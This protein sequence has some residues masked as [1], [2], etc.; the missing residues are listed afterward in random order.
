MG[1]ASAD[2][3]PVYLVGAQ[4]L[5]LGWA[6]RRRSITEVVD[7]GDKHGVAIDAIY[8][9]EKLTF[10]TVVGD[11]ANPKDHGVVTAY[12]GAAADA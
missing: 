8:G 4:A 7:Y 3:S 2:V 1:A 12:V 10:G 9:L 6:K 5:G 11:T